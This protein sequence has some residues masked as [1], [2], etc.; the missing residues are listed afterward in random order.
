MLECPDPTSLTV[1]TLTGRPI[2]SNG[3]VPWQ[4]P[5]L[6]PQPT[7][8]AAPAE[9]PA[10]RLRVP[11]ARPLAVAPS[12]GQEERQRDHPRQ[13]AG[14]AH[15]GRPTAPARRRPAGRQPVR[16]RLGDRYL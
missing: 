7:L 2:A 11:A 12:G 9:R 8:A 3:A 15:P 1:P 6:P 13:R 16:R 4:Q 10:A 14:A 5:A